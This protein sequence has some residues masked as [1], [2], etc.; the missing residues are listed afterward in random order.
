LNSLLRTGLALGLFL[1]PALPAEAAR[2]YCEA[3]VSERLDPL[4]VG[5]SEISGIDYDIQRTG[6][7]NKSNRI[8]AWVS[9]HSCNG[10]VIVDLSRI[11]TVRQVYG[12]DE[13]NLGGAVQPW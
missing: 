4:N 11:C 2:K 1:L 8:L 7:R 5:P 12:R 13:C 3:Q 10:Y 6:S 9:L